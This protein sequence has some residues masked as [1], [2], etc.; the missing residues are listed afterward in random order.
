MASRMKKRYEP[1]NYEKVT[2]PAEVAKIKAEA[3]IKVP[4]PEKKPEPVKE[5]EKAAEPAKE[6]KTV[7]LNDIKAAIDD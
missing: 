4:E 6:P 5:Q 1:V 2:D 7:T 3:G